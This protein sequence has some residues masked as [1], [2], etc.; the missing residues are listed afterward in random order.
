MRQT[1]AVGVIKHVEFKEDIQQQDVCRRQR[2][3]P[4]PR[5][6]PHPGSSSLWQSSLLK[7]WLMLIKTHRK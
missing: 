5:S 6:C 7:D 3:T 1:V 4:S 2:A